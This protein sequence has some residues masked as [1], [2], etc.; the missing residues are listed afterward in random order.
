[1]LGPEQLNFATR[2]TPIFLEGVVAVRVS[3]QMA[4]TLG[5]RDNQIIRG[6]LENRGGL[7]KLMFNNHAFDWA[8]SKRSRKWSSGGTIALGNHLI[9]S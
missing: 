1:M 6:V 5:L 7:L 2:P 8:G 3:E 4:K 9:K